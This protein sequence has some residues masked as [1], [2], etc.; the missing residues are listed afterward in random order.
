MVGF[1][2][3]VEN[4]YRER[5]REFATIAVAESEDNVKIHLRKTSET[6][7]ATVD[8]ETGEVIEKQSNA[9]TSALTPRKISG[10]SFS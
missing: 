2:Y 7:D 9:G 4:T 6:P 10:D 8:V 3:H 1:P 5:I